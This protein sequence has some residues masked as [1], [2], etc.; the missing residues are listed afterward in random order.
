[1]ADPIKFYMDEHVPMAITVGLRLRDVD[2]LTTQEADMLAAS[3][4][5]HLSLA[6][7][8]GRGL[9]TQNV[10]F[11]CLHARG[12]PHAGIAYARQKTPVGNIVRGLMLI[13]QVLDP[14]DMLNHVEFL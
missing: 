9:F 12:I 10:D 6:V 5:D 2:V 3:D 1:M 8:E 11:L 7:R 13:Y 4:K 14:E